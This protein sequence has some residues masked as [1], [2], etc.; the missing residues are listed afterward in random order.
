MDKLVFTHAGYVMAK[1]G[2][3]VSAHTYGN[4]GSNTGPLSETDECL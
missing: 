3:N 1:E 2:G 4:A